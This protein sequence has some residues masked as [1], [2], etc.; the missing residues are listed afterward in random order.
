MCPAPFEKG[1]RMLNKNTFKY[2]YLIFI[3]KKSRRDFLLFNIIGNN[4]DNHI[5]V[6]RNSNASLYSKNIIAHD[7]FVQVRI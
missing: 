2:F 5:S 4:Y 7:T 6:R 3:M 1:F